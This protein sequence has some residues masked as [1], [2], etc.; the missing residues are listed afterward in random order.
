MDHPEYVSAIGTIAIETIE[1]EL[2][3]AKL[4]ARVLNVSVVVGRA[5]FLS[6]KSEQARLDM[7]RNAAEA[8]FRKKRANAAPS[9]VHGRQKSTALR[10]VNRVIDRSQNA[11]NHRNRVTHDEWDVPDGEQVAV[12]KSVDGRL[13]RA[14]SVVPLSELHAHTMLPR[15]LIDDVSKLSAE[16]RLRPPNMIDLSMP[17]TK[18][19]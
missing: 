13:S 16:L 18:S 7:L 3:L 19:D 15:R 12:R 2:E 17:S 9:H 11:F 4:F 14:T 1:L 6:P 10:K 5:V 8:A